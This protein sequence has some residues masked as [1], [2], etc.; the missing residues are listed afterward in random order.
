MAV[1]DGGTAEWFK[2]AVRTLDRLVAARLPKDGF[3]LIQADSYFF[4]RGLYHPPSEIRLQRVQES[5][6]LIF[7]CKLLIVRSL[8]PEPR[9]LSEVF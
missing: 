7:L 9:M 1:A 6:R 4:M 3:E 5:R 8:K 2:V